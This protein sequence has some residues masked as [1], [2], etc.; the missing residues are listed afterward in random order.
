[1]ELRLGWL[2]CPLSPATAPSMMSTPA[3]AAL[4][5]VLALR[6]LVSWVWKWMGEADVLA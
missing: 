1:M 5:R 6:P 3:S 2:V 4:R